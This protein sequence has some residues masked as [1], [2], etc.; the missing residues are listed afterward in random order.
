MCPRIAHLSEDCHGRY[1]RSPNDAAG[2]H[3]HPLHQ[4]PANLTRWATGGLCRHHALGRQRSI[5]LQHLDGGHL[6][7]SHRFTT[8]PKR[9][10]KPNWSPDG[11]RLA[12]LSE[13]EA[14]PKA[15]VYVMPAAGGEPTG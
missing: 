12:F 13:R 5:P 2:S 3:P 6:G 8:G 10:T 7:E 14:H 9:D 15:Q 4:R 1:H 11:T